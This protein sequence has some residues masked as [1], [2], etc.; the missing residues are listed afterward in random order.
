M[1]VE[2]RGGKV[3]ALDV[4]RAVR[5]ACKRFTQ[6]LRHARRPGRNHEYFPAVLLAKAQRFFEG[7]RIRLVQ[8]P[9]GVG[10]AHPG[11]GLVDA[12]LPLASHDLF[13]TDGDFHRNLW[14]SGRRTNSG[15]RTDRGLWTADPGLL[16]F[17][18]E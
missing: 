5:T 16:I 18:H 6:H 17:F 1:I 14:N 8:F 4:N 2:C 9:A 7:V 3:V 15:L 11:P 13:D 10:I 12:D